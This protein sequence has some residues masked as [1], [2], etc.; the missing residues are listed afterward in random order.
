MGS[1]SQ[2]PVVIICL[3]LGPVGVW[4]AAATLV[5]D[6]LLEHM[7]PLVFALPVA[8]LLSLVAVLGSRTLG[9]VTDALL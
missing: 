4:P 3:H 7:N 1:S 8:M 5:T 6:V 2:V 9:P